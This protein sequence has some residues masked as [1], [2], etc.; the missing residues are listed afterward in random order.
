MKVITSIVFLLFIAMTF[1]SWAEPESCEH[2]ATEFNCVKYLKNYD[3]DTITFNIPNVHP[4]IGKKVS[5]RVNGVD[6][7]EVRT[8]DQCEKDSAR[9]ARKLVKNLLKRAQRI[10][11]K[12]VERGKYFRI[13]A[14]VIVDGKNLKDILISN[15]L[16]YSYDG[17]KKPKTNWCEMG[18]L[19]AQDH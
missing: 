16:A 9:A 10:D 18:R 7:A 14:D 4:V 12:N 6:T 13:V 17:S 11:L 19:P 1:S 2:S 5:V 8:K 15:R 3:G